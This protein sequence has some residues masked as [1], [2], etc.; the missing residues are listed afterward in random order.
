MVAK[1]AN[2]HSNGSGRDSY[3]MSNGGGLK[4]DFKGGNDCFRSSLRDTQRLPSRG[5]AKRY[6]DLIDYQKQ[7]PAS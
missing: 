5:P 2:Y 4:P 1:S 7:R 3:I 6:K